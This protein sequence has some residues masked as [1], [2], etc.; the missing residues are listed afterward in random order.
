M[1]FAEELASKQRKAD[2]WFYNMN[3]KEMSDYILIG[4]ETLKNLAIK[5]D[6]CQEVYNEAYK[7][8][9]FR[10]SGKR[11]YTLKDGKIRKEN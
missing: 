7:I 5:L 6:I 9:D 8:Y 3:N 1:V 4:A 10:N 2:L 11:G